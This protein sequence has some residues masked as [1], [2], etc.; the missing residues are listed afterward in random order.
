M[1][2]HIL[3]FQWQ[4]W[5]TQLWIP[6]ILF[7]VEHSVPRSTTIMRKCQALEIKVVLWALCV[8]TCGRIVCVSA[9]R[10]FPARGHGLLKYRPDFYSTFPI[11]RILMMMRRMRELYVSSFD[12]CSALMNYVHVFLILLS[13]VLYVCTYY[14]WGS[15]ESTR[16]K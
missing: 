8:W 4:C 12:V 14:D 5:L 2:T 15:S 6:H 7:T 1:T 11:Y 16:T 10:T 9:Y 3:F 13:I